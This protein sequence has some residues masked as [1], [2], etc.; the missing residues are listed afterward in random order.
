MTCQGEPVGL[1]P[2]AFD[3]LQLLVERRG[4]VLSKEEMLE[5][6][7]PGSFVE[8]SN[9][10]QNIYTLRKALGEQRAFIETLPRRGYRF[11]GPVRE[12]SA[13][14]PAAAVPDSLAVLPFTALTDQ[15]EDRYLGLGLA[16]AVI[17]RMTQLQRFVVRP[18]SAIRPWLE[19]NDGPVAAGQ[20]LGVD[21]VLEGTLQRSGSDIRVTAQ[22]VRVS[23]GVPLWAETFDGDDASVFELQDSISRRLAG[24][25]VRH[26]TLQDEERLSRRESTAVPAAF[27]AYVKGRYYWNKRSGSALTKAIAC[28]REALQHDPAYAAAFS[29]IADCYGLLP[30]HGSR[31]PWECFP[32][33]REAAER[34]LAL[35]PSLAEAHTSRA[36]VHFFFDR[37]WSAAEEEFLRALELNSDYPTG[38]HWY[39]YYLSAMGRHDEAIDRA[40]RALELDPSSLVI[41]TDLALVYYFARRFEQAE[42]HASEALELDPAFS[43]G[44]FAL[45]HTYQQQGRLDRAVDT[46]RQGVERS[47]GSTTMLASWA[48]ALAAAGRQE[49]AHEVMARLEERGQRSYVDPFHRGLIELAFGHHDRAL[50]QFRAACEDRSRF[51]VLLGVWPVSDALRQEPGW[52]DLLGKVGLPAEGAGGFDPEN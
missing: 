6:L 50:E 46:F 26:W 52:R 48:Q 40:R 41:N 16:D 43:Y 25:L 22:L 36:Y 24:S 14:A 39:S 19:R 18:T 5:S 27:Q 31:P 21:A 7:W 2:K 11:V 37:D 1:T 49:E 13:D 33:A 12:G 15:P 28:F 34:A 8:E 45:A 35:E 42:A 20:A 29:G 47:G 32:Q 44:C 9:L 23:D 17:T 38:Y 51:V 10:S 4:E 30:I 3:T